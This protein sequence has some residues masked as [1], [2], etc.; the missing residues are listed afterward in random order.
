MDLGSWC[1]GVAL[2][3]HI[4]H[5]RHNWDVPSAQAPARELSVDV[6]ELKKEKTQLLEERDQL[7]AQLDDA[8]ETGPISLH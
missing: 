4:G 5:L 6:D 3:A 2:S 8:D 7:L 1:S